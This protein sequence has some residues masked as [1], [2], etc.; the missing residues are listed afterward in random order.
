MKKLL[1]LVLAVAMLLS[2]TAFAGAEGAQDLPRNETVYMGGYQWGSVVGWNPLSSNNNCYPISANPRGSRSVMF[3]TLYMYNMLDGGLYPL[4]A[5]GEVNGYVWNDTMTEL[6]VTIKEAAYWSDFEP[7]TANDVAATWKVSM[8][9]QN[10]NYNNFAAYIDDV[11]AVDE[12]TV[13]IK[14][15]QNEEGGPVNPLQLLQY[16]T[17]VYV[18]QEGW[19]NRIVEKH[20]GDAAAILGDTCEDDIVFSGPYGKYFANDQLVALVRNDDYWGQDASM[21]GQLPVP[22]YIAHGIYSDNDAALVAFKAGDIDVNQQFIANVQ[23]L[24]LVDGLPIS[25][26][27]SEAPYGICA[28]MPTAWYNMET[29]ALQNVAVRKAIAMAVDYDNIIANAMT[30]QSPSFADV[31]RSVMNP[32]DGE[33]AL[34]DHEAV[35]D[36]QWVGNDIEGAK[37]LLD[38][39]GIVDTDGDGYR[40]LNGAKIE[41][42]A[43]CPNGWTD[44]QAA[45]QIVAEA[46]QNIGLDIQTFYPEYSVYQ[47]I[48]TAASQTEYDIFMWSPAGAQPASPWARVRALMSSEFLGQDNNWN[49]NFGHWSNERADEIIAAIPTTTDAEELKALYTEATQIYLTEVPSFS[50]MYRPES[51]HAVNE[52]VWTGY[53]VA[54]DGLN[55]PP[56]NLSE[57]YGVAGLYHIRNVD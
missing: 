37:A 33:Q 48:F 35:K 31:P 9:I 27:M 10:G 34:F 42:K 25:T 30:N 38:E 4:L 1:S 7:V 50:L 40:E 41:L 46:G 20:N 39:A 19:L 8:D 16:L 43:C 26:Y 24:W 28:T 47:T 3:E 53:P 44:W 45:M 18:L 15:K 13:V 14:A 52:S 23:N 56:T 29:P 49:G 57:G 17:G 32:T 6:T 51:F 11:V 54:G 5:D 55:I 2:V 12:H 36:L 22:K 21:W